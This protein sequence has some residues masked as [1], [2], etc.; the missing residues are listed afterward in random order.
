MKTISGL[1]LGASLLCSTVSA[2][3]ASATNNLAVYWGQN[4]A[5]SQ[6]SLASYCQDSTIDIIPI[7]FLTA[8]GV[9]AYQL[10]FANACEGVNVAG[11]TLLQCDQIAADIKTCQ[12]AGKKILLSVGGAAG[13]YGFSSAAQATQ[14][15]DD[16]WNY[17]GGGSSSIRPFGTAI[18]DG[19]DLDIENNAP[20]YYPNFISQMRAHYAT[21]SLRAY[22][23]SGA[24]QC[25]YPDASLKDA[26]TDSYFD[27]LFIQFYNNWCGVYQFGS[28][29]GAFNYDVWHT[30][31]TT[32]SKNPAVKLFLGVA[33]AQ[34][35]ANAGTGY[36]APS[37]MVSAAQSLQSQ[38]PSSF[39]GIMMW[40]A[41]QAY[42]NVPS[43]YSINYAQIAKQAVGGVV[44]Q[45]T[46]QA[47]T[48]SAKAAVVTTKATTATVVAAPVTTTKAA[49]VPV[50]TSSSTKAAV[51]PA[52]TN[53]VATTST[54]SAVAA[55]SPATSAHCGKQ[56][57]VV[58]GD[59]CYA[60]WTKYG[61]SSDTFYSLNPTLSASNNCAIVPGQVL[62]IGAATAAAATGQAT[63]S[64]KASTSTSTTT[65]TVKS[66]STTTVKTPALSPS[67]S[68]SVAAGAQKQ[69]VPVTTQAASTSTS[70]AK[71]AAAAAVTT[72][73]SSSSCPNV[74]DACSPGAY[75]C[76]GYGYLQC[77][78]LGKWLQR[79]CPAGTACAGSGSNIYCDWPGASTVSCSGI[80]GKSNS[81]RALPIDDD[82]QE[83][84]LLEEAVEV[85]TTMSSQRLNGT[86]F[87]IT[88]KAAA[89][90]IMPIPE[91]WY[92]S[93]DSRQHL[94]ESDRGVLFGDAES[95][96][97]TV[98][99]DPMTTYEPVRTLVVRLTGI[100]EGAVM[101]PKKSW[102]KW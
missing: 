48:T 34:G 91:D 21:D 26:L 23:I 60:I 62:C 41:S 37:L 32:V 58:S 90:G 29:S 85:S 69:A 67:S 93:F 8:F 10:N 49:I 1:A 77:D 66:T 22:Y 36:V 15:A 88:L 20:A 99:A 61:L 82:E 86:H 43:G 46:Q 16:M 52:T 39:G 71:A 5:G 30:W 50:T 80:A 74:S 42:A 14:A 55:A 75:A 94:L 25:V 57:T 89:T 18:V 17:F 84:R 95:G 54:S 13:S 83:R 73:L 78:G 9:G 59:Y 3:S 4:S 19:F 40:D 35:A 76:N 38:Y 24:P 96:R 27:F 72:T 6:K 2:F 28:S 81:K 92:F 79:D 65:T 101:V 100:Y 31:A 44:S 11:S 45:T 33:A 7:S 12:A 53:K 97:Y 64:S 63:T 51:T 98:S 70:V 56:Y 47:S 87:V 68:S 102:L